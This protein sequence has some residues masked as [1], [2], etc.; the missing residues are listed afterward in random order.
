MI[1]YFL[2]MYNFEFFEKKHAYKKN[3][4]VFLLTYILTVELVGEEIFSL[5]LFTGDSFNSIKFSIFSFQVFI[6]LIM[7]NNM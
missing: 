3:A 7:L 5:L 2:I 1:L 4:A 6:H